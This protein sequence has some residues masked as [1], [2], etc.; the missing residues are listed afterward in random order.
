MA[1]GA[2]LG[3][4]GHRM[5]YLGLAGALLFVAILPL[6][7]SPG[8]LPPPDFMLALTFA[9][10]LRRPEYVPAWLIVAVFLTQDLM[11]LRPPGLWAL[12][13]LLG[14]EFLRQREPLTRELP[15]WLEWVLVGAVIVAMMALNRLV[16]AIVMSPQPGFGFSF[17]QSLF[18]IAIYP[19]VVALSYLGLGLRKAATCEIDAKGRR[20]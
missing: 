5:L 12:M 11:T 1:E 20:L 16:L 2:G 9:W 17:L 19:A 14:A 18:T 4:L 6:G 8:E 3:V 13:V 10:V 15:F 7:L